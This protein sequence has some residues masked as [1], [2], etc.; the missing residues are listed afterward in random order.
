MRLVAELVVVITIYLTF[1]LGSILAGAST[2]VQ[3][4]EG[5]ID[6]LRFDFISRKCVLLVLFLTFWNSDDV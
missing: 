2:Q 5:E 1:S 4:K 6:G 3:Y